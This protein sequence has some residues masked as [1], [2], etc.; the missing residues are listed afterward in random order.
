MLFKNIILFHYKM[1]K[2]F[3]LVGLWLAIK[4][5]RTTFLFILDIYSDF[6]FASNLIKFICGA[7]DEMSF[8][9]LDCGTSQPNKWLVLAFIT[10]P[11]IIPLVIEIVQTLCCE[12]SQ[13]P[14]SFQFRLTTFIAK[15]LNQERCLN[16]P[17]DPSK[18]LEFYH[19]ESKAC[20]NRKFKF[21]VF[22][23]FLQIWFQL[24]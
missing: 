10:L 1:V 18:I 11:I 8:A 24:F 22:E 14:N 21:I 15:M 16:L 19:E 20:S 7:N 3:K 9:D 2:I 23:D 12:E 17:Q 5:L 13:G 4:S 6:Q